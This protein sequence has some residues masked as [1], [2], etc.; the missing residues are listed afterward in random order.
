MS[1]TTWQPIETAPKDG[2]WI[3]LRGRNAVDHPMVPVVVAWNPPGSRASGVGWRDSGSFRDC[4]SLA[5]TVGAD[6]APLPGTTI[7]RTEA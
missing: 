5:G 4:D 7:E 2:T 1:E 6:W 3:L